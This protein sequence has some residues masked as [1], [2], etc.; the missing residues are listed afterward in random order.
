MPD[1]NRMSQN[2]STSSSS[3]G[4]PLVDLGAQLAAI[5]DQVDS[6]LARVLDSHRFILG[7]E[8]EAFESEIASHIDCRYAIGV[9]SG[10]D[11]L[12][13]S[14]MALDIG[15]GDEVIT[16]P[17]LF[18][19]TAGCIARLGAKP[20]FVDIDP[21]TFLLNENRLDE[22]ITGR[23][24]A[25]LPV[26]L[27]G[28]CAAMDVINQVADQ[29]ELKIVE[30]ATQAIGARCA[31]RS[32]GQWSQLGCFSFFP[33]K[34]LGGCG[35]GGLITTDDDLLAER[36]RPLRSH[37]FAPKYYSRL[38]GGNFRLDA[39]QAAILRVKLP[40]LDAW[41]SARRACAASYNGL[42]SDRGLARKQVASDG[43]VLPCE[44]A[45]RRHVYHQYVIRP[46]AS[47]R[48]AV[49]HALANRGIAT[50]VYYPATLHL[51]DCF[52]NLGYQR[53]DF[54]ESERAAAE[55]LALPL[56]PEL[57]EKLQMGVVDAVLDYYAGK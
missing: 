54:P 36:V 47:D 27:Y 21:N 48:E 26:H 12:L 20:V 10:T 52:G 32:A 25:I 5:R 31:D 37:G 15:P 49:R 41:N 46:A 22:A 40:H 38:L 7:P 35:D 3:D 55:T 34:N 16:T 6:A 14:L 39:L 11:A 56:Y 50:E 45:G 19:A 33:T 1:P 18:I 30:D 8:V 2:E 23:T 43:V 24:R 29:H 28:Q 57:T 51:Q 4:V 9:S 44:Q 42:L 53:G 17:F 13:V